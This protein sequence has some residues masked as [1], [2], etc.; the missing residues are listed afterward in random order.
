MSGKFKNLAIATGHAMIGLA[1]GP[2]TGKLIANEFNGEKQ[3]FDISLFSPGR[4]Q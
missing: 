4:Y 1:L 3:P 2:A